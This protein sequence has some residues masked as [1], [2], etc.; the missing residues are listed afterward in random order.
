MTLSGVFLVNFT[1]FDHCFGASI[2]D[3][4]Q[5]AKYRPGIYITKDVIQLS[6][7]WYHEWESVLNESLAL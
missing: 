2:V 7:S 4:E 6:Y 1:D 3:F 5:V